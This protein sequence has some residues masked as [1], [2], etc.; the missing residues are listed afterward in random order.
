VGVATYK[1]KMEGQ[2][3]MLFGSSLVFLYT[4]ATKLSSV[5]NVFLGYLKG[6]ITILKYGLKI[7]TNLT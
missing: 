4:E 5:Y 6:V 7:N 1:S 2:D 3:E